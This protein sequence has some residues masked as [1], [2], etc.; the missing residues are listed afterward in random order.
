MRVIIS[1]AEIR[2]AITDQLLTQTLIAA[3]ADINIEFNDKPSDN[4]SDAIP[5][6]IAVIDITLGAARPKTEIQRTGRILVTTGGVTDLTQKAGETSEE[7]ITRAA[8]EAEEVRTGRGRGRPPGSKNK[9]KDD[10]PAYDPT[11][12]KNEAAGLPSDN[13][14]ENLEPAIAPTAVA[15]VSPFARLITPKPE[16]DE[17]VEA[18][19]VITP[20]AGDEPVEEAAVEAVTEDAPVVTTMAAEEPAE[21]APAPVARKSLFGSLPRRTVVEEAPAAT[22]EAAT[23][24]PAE[25]EAVIAE[26]EAPKPTRSLFANLKT[27]SNKSAG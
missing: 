21:E 20:A 13:A 15:S 5:E 24:E 25:A 12:D 19:V 4:T 3:G 6:L 23:K 8:N 14:D 2:R 16:A 10:T 27:I 22:V 17:P 9:P 1:E 26:E 7:L 11:A 18:P